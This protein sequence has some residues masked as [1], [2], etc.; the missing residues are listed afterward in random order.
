MV[1]VG[2]IVEGHCEK[3]VL[4]S[5]GFHVFLSKAGVTNVY[6]V[7][8]VKGK[9][10][11]LTDTATSLAQ[12]L[13]DKG[14]THILVLR[15]LDDLPDRET[16]QKEVIRAIDL[17]VCVAVRELEAWFLADSDTLSAI[18][19]TSFF[20]E[21]PEQ[22]SN[23]FETLNQLSRQFRQGRGIDDKRKFT[24]LMLANGFSIEKAAEHP[25]CPSARYF[26]TTLQTLASAN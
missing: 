23:P 14:A 22:E 5:A 3:A 16:A 15:D 24:N 2:F 8:N 6:D 17:S 25:N 4:G 7:Q 10:N 19:K 1:N 20:F 11:L 13:R 18:F 12:I 9:D 26:L 21:H